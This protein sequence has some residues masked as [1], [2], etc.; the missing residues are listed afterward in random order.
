MKIVI[1][2]S[3]NRKLDENDDLGFEKHKKDQIYNHIDFNF[4]PNNFDGFW[5]DP[6]KDAEIGIHLIIFYISGVTFVT[7]Y[8][9]ETEEWFKKIVDNGH[10]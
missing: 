10:I 4:N 6:D 9:K 8:S 2:V 5:V 1:V 7:P 3:N